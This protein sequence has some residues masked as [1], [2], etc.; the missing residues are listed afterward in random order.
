VLNTFRKADY[1]LLARE[2]ERYLDPKM[3][4]SL[5]TIAQQLRKEGWKIGEEI[6]LQRGLQR[7]RKEGIK[8]EKYAVA[9]KLLKC[10][11]DPH[12]I[13]KGTDLPLK[14]LIQLKK[15]LE[16]VELVGEDQ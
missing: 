13:C 6:G 11:L 8:Y 14:E 3:G 2:I 5:M 16:S 4:G 12:I 7:G 15:K 9:E 1:K 10:G